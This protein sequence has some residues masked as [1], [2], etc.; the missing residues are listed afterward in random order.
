[1]SIQLK[2][3]KKITNSKLQQSKKPNLTTKQKKPFERLNNKFAKITCI[4]HTLFT[5]ESRSKAGLKYWSY[6]SKK[7]YASCR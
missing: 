3:L 7:A 2:I 1:M 5:L 4:L 6:D